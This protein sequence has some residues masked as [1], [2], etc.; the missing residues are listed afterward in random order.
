MFEVMQ[1]FKND[2]KKVVSNKSGIHDGPVIALSERE[3][4]ESTIGTSLEEIWN[5]Y[6]QE[7][8]SGNYHIN[9]SDRKILE[10]IFQT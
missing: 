9:S 1:N 8:V 5:R 3:W 10:Q 6:G 4:S 7:I 2:G